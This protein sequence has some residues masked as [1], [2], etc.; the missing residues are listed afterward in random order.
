VTDYL[1]F[2]TAF[3][4]SA[5]APGADTFLIATR[6]LESKAAAIWAALGITLAKMTMVTLVFF[7]VG[8]A[9]QSAPWILVALKIFGV[10]FL[11]FRAWVLWTKVPGSTLA[12]ASGRDFVTGFTVGF[13]NPQPFAFYLSVMPAIIASTQVWPLLGIVSIGFA[14]VAGA[15][16]LATIPLQTWLK[17]S[18]NQRA[19]NRTLGLVF[20]LIA[21]WIAVL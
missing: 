3:M 7:G 19:V 2:A 1:L 17:S 18:T 13:S 6:A 16:I 11:L 8:A 14:V 20:V 4:A 12:R 5:I 9:L 10:G 21:I 15:Y